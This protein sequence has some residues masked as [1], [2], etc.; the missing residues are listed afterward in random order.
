MRATTR[1]MYLY[2]AKEVS[3]NIVDTGTGD[4]TYSLYGD[5]VD[6][7]PVTEYEVMPFAGVI[8][9]LHPKTIKAYSDAGHSDLTHEIQYRSSE[10]NVNL[11]D[12]VKVNDSYYEV[13]RLPTNT[14]GRHRRHR[15]LV[16][17]I[18]EDLGQ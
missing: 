17:E 3:T 13:L 18:L 4:I 15:L 12:R 11:Y 14:D 9:E 5:D 2:R 1:R 10:L 7:K 8:V 6:Y 16:K